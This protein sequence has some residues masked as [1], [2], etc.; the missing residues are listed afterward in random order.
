MSEPEYQP[1]IQTY[2]GDFVNLMSTR[3]FNLEDI[4]HALSQ[5]CRF[6]GHTRFH[7]SVAQH[8]VYVSLAMPVSRPRLRLAALLH[9]AAEAYMSDISSPL[10]HVLPD[11]KAIETSLLQRIFDHFG[12]GDLLVS[13]GAM[14]VV[15][16]ADL[17]MFA[18]E[19]DQLLKPNNSHYWDI[20]ED[21]PRAVIVLPEMSARD[22]KE[23]FISEYQEIKAAMGKKG[24]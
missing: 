14:D 15:K 19:R 20:I 18:T 13:P 8:S 9:D 17:M 22:A 10:K 21:I 3:L 23:M 11:Y 16:K 4:A 2:S 7:Y 6:S 1:V 24:S 12:I 5:M